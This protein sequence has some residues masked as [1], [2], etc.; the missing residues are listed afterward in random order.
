[1]VLLSLELSSR[2]HHQHARHTKAHFSTPKWALKHLFPREGWQ[3]SILWG[4]CVW[5]TFPLQLELLFQK[6]QAS[7][8]C[9][10]VMA[11]FMVPLMRLNF[12]FTNVWEVTIS[13]CTC[14]SFHAETLKSY[15]S[16]E[17]SG[18]YMRLFLNCKLQVLFLLQT[19]SH[20]LAE[21]RGKPPSPLMQGHRDAFSVSAKL[22]HSRDKRQQPRSQSTNDTELIESTEEFYFLYW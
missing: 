3:H 5:E 14:P 19:V 2:T 9:L 13:S 21:D 12:H 22:H 8:F 4:W 11:K 16:R 1:M 6:G 10:E 17:I 15:S 20:F 7:F 18:S